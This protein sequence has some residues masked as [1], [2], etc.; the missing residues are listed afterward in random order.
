[1]PIRPEPNHSAKH[2]LRAARL[3]IALL[4]L[5][6]PV[7][8]QI[9]PTR[10]YLMAFHACEGTLCQDF[11]NHSVYLAESADGAAWSL[12][13][14]WTPFVGSVPDVIQRGRT[15]YFYTSP[16][17]VARYNLDT[18]TSDL[19]PVAVQGLPS[20]GVSDW[21]DAS[22]YVDEEGRLVL[23]MMHAEPPSRDR[24]PSD[25]ASCP[26][27]VTSCTKA[28]LSATEVPDS[29]GTEFVVDPGVRATTTISSVTSPRTAADP[30]IFFD[31][32]QYVLYISHGPSTS[33][34]TS[35]TLRGTYT[36]S[37]RLPSGLLSD[38]RGG[39]PAGHFDIATSRYWTYTH[40]SQT[41]TTVIRRAVHAALTTPLEESSW[42]PVITGQSVGLGP[43]ISVESPSF[44]V[45]SSSA[46]ASEPAPT[47]TCAF[48]TEPGPV[49]ATVVG[50]EVTLVWGGASGA[51]GYALE[52][53]RAA[54]AS[55]VA[56][57]QLA[58]AETSISVR[59]VPSGSH[60]VRVRARNACGETSV[61]PEIVVT[62]P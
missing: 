31:G 13:P 11:R 27:D 9:A 16:S 48:L 58:S 22:L 56:T 52:L 28:F 29:D 1:M 17:M 59:N 60:Y 26:P 44:A 4:A 8:A 5:S 47:V 33:V 19:V 38:G 12:V 54:G 32:T 36:L 42:Q 14:G 18:G 23:F 2:A 53:G 50:H 41:G 62:V 7:H 46:P 61:S 45:L 30:D 10:P 15:L 39:V 3:S 40:Q 34:W 57:G 21:V 55:N 37:T 49:T 25:P 6:M 51:S 20:G 43:H 35:P 24:P